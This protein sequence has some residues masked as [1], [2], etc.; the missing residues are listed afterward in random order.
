MAS[1]KQASPDSSAF[2]KAANSCPICLDSLETEECSVTIIC[3]HSFHLECLQ[4]WEDESCPI[5]RY[6]QYPFSLVF[7]EKCENSGDVWSCVICGFVGCGPPETGHIHSHS[8]ETS[9]I[10]SKKL[11]FVT[12]NRLTLQRLQDRKGIW[13]HSRS[14]FIDR[15]TLNENGQL[16]EF[17]HKKAARFK[18]NKGLKYQEELSS[19]IQIQLESQRFYYEEMI[20]NLQ[21][22]LAFMTQENDKISVN[23]QEEIME[24]E[25]KE[26]AESTEY[27]LVENEKKCMKV[28]FIQDLKSI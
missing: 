17:S 12:F 21:N 6:Q 11:S 22:E 19:L 26:K 27:T 24:L 20:K 28:R 15:L 7:C 2:K 1:L 16:A 4:K 18:Q 23:I 8:I 25:S 13:D 9:H 14:N 5:C 3:E 10:Y